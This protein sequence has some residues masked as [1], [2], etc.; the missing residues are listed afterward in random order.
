MARADV[1][2]AQALMRH[3]RASRHARYLSSRNIAPF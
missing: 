3:S 1:N 2:D